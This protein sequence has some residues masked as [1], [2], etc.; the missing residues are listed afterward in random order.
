[1]RIL[2]CC[3]HFYPSVGGVQKVMLEL[4][5]RFISFGHEVEVVASYRDDRTV[6]N[7]NGLKIH[8][9]KVYGNAVTGMQGEIEAYQ[10]F[11]MGGEYDFLLVMA[12]QQWTLDAMLPVLDQIPY[13]KFQIPCGYSCFYI[14]QYQNY[15]ERMKAYLPKFDELIYNSSDYRDI[16]FARDLGL[17]N[18][19]IIPVGAGED[20]FDEKKVDRDI[21]KKLGIKDEFVFLSVGA[22]VYNK[23][24]AEVLNAYKMAKLEYKSVL[25]LNGN[26]GREH[27]LSFAS[28]LKSP[29]AF[30]K[31]VAMRFLGRSP[32][33]IQKNAKRI[34]GDKKVICVDLA[35][36]E[37]IS[38]FYE[39]DLFVFASHI[40]YSPLVIFECLAAGLPFLSTPVGNV[41]EIVRWS[42][43]GEVFSAKR[44]P[45]GWV[46]ADPQV[47]AAKM[48]KL[49]VD[50]KRLEQMSTAGQEAWRKKFTWTKMAQ[51]IESLALKRS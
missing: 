44:K 28:L 27:K 5:R 2:L 41:D 35:R 49:A 15:Y 47:L 9:F 50:P 31:E 12:A 30:A 20:E 11:L 23:G 1:M 39:A 16:N 36:E 24:Q 34:K 14:P 6:F 43:G 25:I 42:G 32:A 21:R 13:R 48:E 51:A 37:L 45:D 17:Q 29:R 40:E 10:E 33:A 38:L 7:V 8:S 46:K 4:G 22:P 26:Y 3:E 19:N 18:I